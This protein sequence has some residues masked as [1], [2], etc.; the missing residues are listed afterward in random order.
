[1]FVL[2]FYMFCFLFY[3]FCDLY[4]LYLR[5]L[6]YWPFV[7]KCKDN[8]YRMETKFNSINTVPCHIVLYLLV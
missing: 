6:P 8:Y 5:V 7:G 2:L 1:M 3:V 4:Y